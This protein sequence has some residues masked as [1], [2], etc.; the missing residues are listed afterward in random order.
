MRSPLKEIRNAVVLFLILCLCS[1]G[2]DSAAIAVKDSRQQIQDAVRRFSKAFVEA[3][4]AILDMLLSEDY[5][6]TNSTG[7][8]LNKQQWLEYIKNRR[9]EL[10]AG[11]LEIES[12]ENTDLRI[13]VHG[14]SAI[15]TGNNVA[16]G[17]IEGKSFVTQLR[18]THLWI[19]QSGQWK[20]VAFHD[21]SI[22]R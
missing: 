14:E 9:A 22:T 10:E 3:D 19:R 20:R 16:K 11:R 13:R 21:S 1:F 17:K 5:I 6:H 4:V 12:Y 7:S 8:V 15:V 18:F 2:Q